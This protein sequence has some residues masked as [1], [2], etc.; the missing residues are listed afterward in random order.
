MRSIRSTGHRSTTEPPCASMWPCRASMKPWLSM[1]PVEG[2]TS[3][4]TQA[5]SGSSARAALA[6][7]G[8]RSPDA[9]PLRR[10]LDGGELGELALVRGDQQLAAARVPHVVLR[11]EAVEQLLAAHAQGGPQAARR[12]V[13]ARRGSPRCCARTSPSRS[14]RAARAPSPRGRPRPARA[15][16]PARPR[17]RRPPR[18]RC[19]R[20]C[21][22][23]S[24]HRATP[25]EKSECWDMV[26][27]LSA[28]QNKS[29]T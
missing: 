14:E 18:S 23:P 2:E 24:R 10:G 15:P 4:A 16:P 13:D 17:R 6:P 28:C 11:A 22:S 29:R 5:S 9:V 8:S 1:M 26:R 19:Q 20:S 12:I 21:A 3:A 27:S 25:A 7:I